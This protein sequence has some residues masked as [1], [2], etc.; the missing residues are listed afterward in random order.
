MRNRLQRFVGTQQRWC[1]AFDRRLSTT[2]NTEGGSHFRETIV[3]AYVSPGMKVFDVGGGKHPFF[4]PQEKAR[5]KLRVF[6][7]DVSERELAGAPPEGYDDTICADICRYS[8]NAKG[9]LVICQAVLEHV[10]DT[11]AAVRGLLSLLKPGGVALIWVPCRNAAFAR[12]NLLLSEH[13]KQKILFTIFPRTEQQHGFPAFYRRCTPRDFLQMAK[14]NGAVA[15]M[16]QTYYQ[17]GYFSFLLP[18]HI[19]WRAW[20]LIARMLVG[21]QACESFSVALRKPVAS[22]FESTFA[23]GSTPTLLVGSAGDRPL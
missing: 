16:M 3:A 19:L 2:C 18:L 20:Q 8:G 23:R 7:I 6:G 1:C 14:A 10:S 22:A 21:D 5:L 9:D 17:N 15:E 12:L 4:S 11:N 13:W